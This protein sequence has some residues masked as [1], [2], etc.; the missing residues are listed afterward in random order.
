MARI[1]MKQRLDAKVDSNFIDK[2]KRLETH[3][4]IPFNTLIEEALNDLL[5]KYKQRKD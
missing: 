1:L 2:L 5:Q 3:K 4:G